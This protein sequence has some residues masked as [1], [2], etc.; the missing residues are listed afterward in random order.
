MV[1]LEQFVLPGAVSASVDGAA[2][3]LG[4]LEAD[5]SGERYQFYAILMVW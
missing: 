2:A 4:A 3:V 5:E 1:T